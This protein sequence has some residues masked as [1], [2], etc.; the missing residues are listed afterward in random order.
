MGI[1]A[2]RLIDSEGGY[3]MVFESAKAAAEFIHFFYSD[4]TQYSITKGVQRLANGSYK[5]LYNRF[6]AEYI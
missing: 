5:T 3:E 6:R 2:T 4:K 1:K